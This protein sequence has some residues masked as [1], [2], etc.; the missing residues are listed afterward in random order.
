MVW[1]FPFLIETSFKE[2]VFIEF[3]GSCLRLNMSNLVINED[4]SSVFIKGVELMLKDVK[5]I[6]SK[7]YLSELSPI[8]HVEHM[9]K[10]FEPCFEAVE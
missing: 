6:N 5:N 8:P 1:Y 9:L 7:G 3:S 2:T 4:F 10:A